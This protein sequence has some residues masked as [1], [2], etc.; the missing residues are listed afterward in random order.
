L[1]VFPKTREAAYI[2]STGSACRMQIK[3]GTGKESVHPI[4]L[5][6]NLLER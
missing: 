5:I 1:G 3:H 4:V 2:V 6:A